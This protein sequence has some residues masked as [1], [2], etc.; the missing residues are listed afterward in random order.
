MRA[1][2]LFQIIL[3]LL[4]SVSV[5]LDATL[6]LVIFADTDEEKIGLLCTQELSLIERELRKGARYADLEF[7]EYLYIERNAICNF[8]ES[9]NQM[10]IAED[11][12]IVLFCLCHGYR[13]SSSSSP[14]PTF[15]LFYDQNRSVDFYYV[16][17]LLIEKKPRFLISI[18][19]SCNQIDDT[20]P[21]LPEGIAENTPWCDTIQ[22]LSFDEILQRNYKH[23]LLESS[24]A[25]I[26]SSSSPGQLSYGSLVTYAF[27]DALHDAVNQPILPDW[28]AIFDHTCTHR[29]YKSAAKEWSVKEQTPQYI[30]LDL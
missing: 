1:A 11:D 18:A 3:L 16:T 4:I 23:L 9:F 21:Y 6:H 12:V 30:Y 24:G 5:K 20:L 15:W 26:V 7:K 14:F 22:K 2:T 13:N 17:K 28:T 27:L 19:N 29:I 25:H 10:E 8:F